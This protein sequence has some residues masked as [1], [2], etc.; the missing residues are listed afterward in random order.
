[1]VANK[2]VESLVRRGATASWAVTVIG[3]EAHPAYDRV[4][5]SDLFRGSDAASLNLTDPEVF[6]DP[7]VTLVTG[8]P[9]VAIDR[10][11][12][13]VATASGLSWPYDR[14]VLAT[15]S[16]PFVP[17]VPGR[18]LPGC[19]AYRTL[20]DV[21]EIKAWSRGRAHG[22]VVGGGLLG[23]EAAD[24]LR[25]CGLA[26]EVVELAPWL[27]PTQV[28]QTG[29]ELLARRVQEMGLQVHAAT[30][31]AR[32]VPGDDGAVAAVELAPA[33]DT[34]S[35]AR[36]S[37]EMVVFAAGIRP[38]D[39]LARAAGIEVG[40][41]GGVV[42]DDRC[43]TSDGLIYAV[44]ECALA[45]GRVHGLVSPGYQMARVVADQLAGHEARFAG[46]GC[47][48]KLKLLGV[49]VASFGDSHARTP[50][51]A[52]IAFTDS[53]AR[54]HKRLVVDD[55]GRL[56]GGVLVGDAGG[57]ETMVAVAAGDLEGPTDPAAL[58]M[59][60]VAGAAEGAAAPGV[61]GLRD[62]A[63][64][65][66]CENVS[67]GAI[68]AAIAAAI[69]SEGEAD[70]ARVR[71]ATRAGTGCGGCLPQISE[72]VRTLMAKAGLELSTRLCE[73][74]DYSR[75]ELFDL[76]RMKGFT[77]F[78]ELLSAYG[79]GRGCEVC[80]PAVASIL[81]STTG[82]H[83]LD[84]D[85]ASLQDTN[86]HFLANLQRDGTYSVVPRI[87][88]G[89]ITPE[90]LIVLGQV[91]SDFKLYTKI[92][93]G[94]RVD[95]LGAR[96][97]DL[98]AI[99][100]RLVDAGFESG[101]AYGK[102]VRTVK[103]CVGTTW[104]RFG[105]Q[106]STGLAVD[107]EMRYRGLRSP[108]KIKMAVS[109]CAREC[110]EAQGKDV[111][112]IATERGWN[113]YVCG[114]GG[115]RP[116]HADLLAE[117]LDRQTLIRSIDRFLVFYIRTAD[118]LQRTASWLEA[119]DG[120]IEHLRRVVMEDSLGLGAELEQ[121]MARHVAR[122]RCEW[123]ETLSDQTRLRRFRTFVNSDA[124]APRHRGGPGAGPAPSGAQVGEGGPG[125][126]GD[127]STR[128][129]V[130][131]CS[132]AELEPGRGVAALVDGR[133][134]ALFLLPGTGGEP[135]VRL[136]AVDNRDPVCGANVISRG[137]VGSQGD[138]DY[139]ASPM[140]KH[141]F[142]LESGACL[143]GVSPGLRVWPV[144]VWGSTVEVLSVVGTASGPARPVATHCPFCALQCGMVVTPEAE[145]KRVRIA[146]DRGFGVNRG[147]LCVKGWSAGE[148][149]SSPERLLTPLVRDA[150]GSL[151]PASWDAAL[152]EVAGR[153]AAVRDS[154]GPASVGVFGSGA[155]TNE[156]AYLLGKFARV[157][158]RTPNVDYNGRYCMSSAAAAANLA[159][160][161]DRG[162][163]F[164]LSDIAR[165][166]SLVLWGANPAD[167]MPPLMGW[168]D[169]M[170]GRG[171][172]LVV[173]DPRR[174]ETAKQADLHVQPVPGSDV[175]LA[176]GLLRRA[177]GRGLVDL[178][179]VAD[180]TSGW[181]E[182]VGL[183]EAW[184]PARVEA[185][186]GLGPS[187]LD[188]LL[189]AL[190]GPPASMLLTGRGPEQQSTGTDAVSAL[191]NLMLALGRVGRP[192]A[193]F[194][195][196]TGQANGQGGR[197]HG[198]KA[199]QLPGYRSISD[200]AARQA[201]AEVW[202]VRA[203]DLPGPGLSAW[204]MIDSI[205]EPGGIHALVVAGSDLRVASPSAGSVARRL[206]ALDCLV[207]LDSFMTDTAST[208]DV[209]LPVS[210]WAE[211]DGTVTN[212]EGRV[213]RR[214]RVLA[215]PAGV[216]S[217]IE[218]LA[219][220]AGRLGGQGRFSY[221]GPEAVFDELRQASAGARADYRGVTYGRLDA[222]ESL[223]WPCPSEDDPGQARLFADG[224]A[225]PDGRARFRPVGYRPPAEVPDEAYPLWFV[226]GRTR[227][228]YNSG[229]QTRRLEGLRAR[230]PRPALQVHP[231][232]AQGMG[233]A[234][235]DEVVVESRRGSARLVI[236]VTEDV[237][238]GVVFAPFHWG[239]EQAA[240]RVTNP[241]LDPISRMPEFKLCAVTL[242]AG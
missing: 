183:A 54:V 162:L 152:D 175:A 156:T 23:L 206:E 153:L 225:H 19:F 68:C 158:L 174:S 67:K 1:M 151:R 80:K 218:V 237:R 165:T 170:R 46:D 123:K 120:G 159:F 200:P 7:A 238:P 99:W 81:A 41:R 70:V 39:E 96:V 78:A 28:D 126:V 142:D 63:T 2:L 155:L 203:E 197:E 210:Q 232:L 64:L 127:M 112:V 181:C 22:V 144:R 87:P 77:S 101:H 241:V 5:L 177:R 179:F 89:E 6:A 116:R 138:I 44:G 13:T 57:F 109:G 11:A 161:I 74:F 216:L 111:G 160:G 32:V 190:A 182:A 12:R 93:G 166:G 34:S 209:I 220:L 114:N 33:G 51:S 172:R 196:I 117:D 121:D 154:R 91:A 45:H 198:Q 129:W 76:V 194:G 235:G 84:G 24:A 113:L 173:V 202:G 29:G 147:R 131:V 169:E 103:S 38:R 187:E 236:E 85:G 178:A 82:R 50:G 132:L 16:A 122:Y 36:L 176:L 92:T 205:G 207:V 189:D 188:G 17:P 55:D 192:Y 9:V 61:A 15:G 88:G 193:G 230:R 30:T 134:V 224:F 229:N 14:L 108:H 219:G 106:D 107:L 150:A 226:T 115:T 97:D 231:A 199:D 42:V 215:P 62:S 222:G 20:D 167:T 40:P 201:V 185:V 95:L 148:L 163:P 72:L 90:G 137:L 118:R 66:S 130:R 124:A 133:Q 75:Q 214:R 47:P 21:E 184:E 26:T 164:P 104:C 69:E 180:R 10:G 157:V 8:D 145:G 223:Y 125:R 79:Q 25:S 31:I 73:H 204:E 100:A 119:M 234:P 140:H 242:I 56:I 135:A 195:C 83:V 43:V 65:C 4:H 52:T 239:G 146:A 227:E 98:P 221:P 228:H 60:A 233:L 48:T 217:D 149:V 240:N 171:G 18:E 86:D 136:R 143:D 102:A 213:L 212:L 58:L 208:A 168:V 139:V 3:E 35:T 27:M 37:T 53:V 94:Q 186:T 49:D 71:A 211:Q 59:P 128:R 141:R 191:I 110:A 105:V